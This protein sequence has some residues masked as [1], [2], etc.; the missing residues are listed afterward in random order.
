MQVKRKILEIDQDRCDGCGNC[1]LACAEGAIRII[2]G[3]ARVV[4]ERFCDGLGACLG[5]CPRDALAIVEREAEEFDETAVGEHLASSHEVHSSKPGRMHGC[6]SAQVQCFSGS[7]LSAAQG[8]LQPSHTAESALTHW[9]IKIRLVP[10]TAGFLKNADLLVAA[11]CTAASYPAFHQDFLA[12]RTVLMGCP[13]FDDVASYVQKFAE[14]FST[15]E[16]RSVTVLVMEVPCCQGLPVIVKKGMELAGKHI[17]LE[18]AVI[19]PNGGILE[20]RAVA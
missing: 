12:G 18:V 5:E 10:A 19:K 4:S 1:V 20:R 16:I 13:K 8:R 17:P 11:D 15:A 14:I 2:D 6:P 9:P 7:Q 3:K